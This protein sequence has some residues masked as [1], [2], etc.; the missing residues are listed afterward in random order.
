[1]DADRIA[2]IIRHDVLDGDELD[3]VEAALHSV[4]A[5]V[6]IGGE[7]A[8]KLVAALHEID[9]RFREIEQRMKP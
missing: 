3:E 4:P 7:I 5:P 1:V 2:P 9:G 8:E 6:A